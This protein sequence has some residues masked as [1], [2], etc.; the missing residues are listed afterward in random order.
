M[1][2]II[3]KIVV[4]IG[5]G[6][7]FPAAAGVSQHISTRVEPNPADAALL[8]RIQRETFNYFW[9]GGEPVSGAAPERIHLDGVYPQ[10]DADVVTSG[11]TGFGI[12][13][14]LVGIER[15]FISREAGRER[16]GKLA[17]W[18]ARADRFHGVWPHWMYPSGKVKPFSKYDNGGDIVE[19]AYLAQG[20]LV[21]REYFK[22]GDEKDRQLA[23]SL[24]QLW[25]GIDWNWYTKGEKVIYWHWSPEFG[26]KMNFAVRGYNECTIL[27]ILAAASPTH[28]VDP[29]CF[30][31]GYMRKGEILSD[32]RSYG[33]ELVLQH[34]TGH[35]I[36]VGPLFWAHYSFLGLD[37]EG[38]SDSYADYWKLNRHHALVH[39][40]YCVENSR[41]YKGY[42]KDCWGLT[43]SY[44]QLGYSAHAPGHDFGVISPT[45]ALS[46]FPYTPEESMRFLKHLYADHP[47]YIGKYGPFD[48]FSEQSNWAPPRYLAIDQ[49]PIPVM[50]ENYRSGLLWKLFMNAPEIQKGLTDLDMHTN[51]Y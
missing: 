47:E 45:A 11:G 27:Y 40:T 41:G 34:N 19:T 25:K 9:E 29:D 30:H 20:L 22:S 46:S 35:S 2:R 18:L 36:P 14:T 49:L 17:D 31:E 26:W 28:P 12:M 48:A 43:A 21:A 1:R 38:L 4:L 24:D 8:D 5:L 39:Y 13:A 6:I 51:K 32:E 44:S 15:G 42:G 37:P 10:A 33:Y 7:L 3:R 23:D 16:L 50:I